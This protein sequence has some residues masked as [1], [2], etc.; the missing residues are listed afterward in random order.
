[1]RAGSAVSASTIRRGRASLVFLLLVVMAVPGFA[2]AAK[3]KSKSKDVDVVARGEK[4]KNQDGSVVDPNSKV[5]GTFKI[6]AKGFPVKLVDLKISNVD[7]RCSKI[8][9]GQY[10]TEDGPE[11]TADL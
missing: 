4:Y 5:T 3:G 8:V 10:Q 9:N 11:A 1:M 6:N 2:L 7:T